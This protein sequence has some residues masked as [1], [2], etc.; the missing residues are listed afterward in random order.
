[1]PFIT[2]FLIEIERYLGVE[3]NVFNIYSSNKHY[4]EAKTKHADI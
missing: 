3:D 2:E 4:D 1:L